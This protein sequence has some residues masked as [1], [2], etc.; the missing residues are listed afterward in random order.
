MIDQIWLLALGLAAQD[1]VAA[2]TVSPIIV[3]PAQHTTQAAAP[4]SASSG[5]P[6][7]TPL[8]FEI[9]DRVHSK[10]NKAGD[11]FRIRLSQPIMAGGAVV[12]PAG[13]TGAGEVIH[14]ARARAA[15]KAGELILTARY[16][17]HDGRRIPLRAFRFGKSGNSHAGT[18]MALGF[19]GG[20][21]AYL[22]VGGEVDVA[23]GTAGYA[24]LAANLD[25]SPPAQ[26]AATPSTTTTQ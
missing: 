6:E 18:A 9:L 23:P 26:T 21:L 24:K 20:P 2:Q 19:A 15:G 10:L 16:I 13:A 8:D 14:A 5:V 1:A 17:E 12:V 11:T 25:L 22:V 7:G 4:D 3:S